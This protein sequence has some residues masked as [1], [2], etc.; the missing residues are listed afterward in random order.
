[1]NW[2]TMIKNKILLPHLVSKVLWL[3]P[4]ALGDAILASSMLQPLHDFYQ[5]ATITVLCQQQLKSLYQACPFVAMI[6]GFDK[7]KYLTDHTYQKYLLDQLQQE[8][9]DMVLNS[10]YSREL[11]MDALATKI[12]A[13]YTVAFKINKRRGRWDFSFRYNRHYWQLVQS[14][15][16]W[17][18]ELARYNDFLKTL[19]VNVQTLLP[20]I[21]MCEEDDVF[22]DSFFQQHHLNART[23]I[24]FFAGA[25][26]EH[27]L[28]Y[29]YGK[30]IEQAFG[31]SNVTV[32]TFGAAAD[33]AINQQNLE[34]L[35][36][37][38]IDLS[39]KTTL[40]QAAAI[41]KRCSLAFGAETGLA[42]MACAVG[43]PNVILLGGGHMGR[44][45][46]YSPL[47]SAVIL[48]LS[49]YGC[50]WR[51]KYKKTYCVQDVRPEVLA[52]VLRETLRTV[53][54]KPRIFV[55]GKNTFENG[56]FKPQWQWPTKF[57]DLSTV[58]VMIVE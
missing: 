18:P 44:F 21:W 9:F 5:H 23:T 45:M 19:G 22:A 29:Q 24:A 10:V 6:I 25:T 16:A 7:K 38:T 8:Q 13:Q 33:S 57:L 50:D 58:D 15:G 14:T 1:M 41:M 39:G 55:Q 12:G 47:T 4:D 32:I 3:R 49:C 31:G 17:K 46:P 11:S 37:P 20:R 51:C 26:S 2:H 36:L 30:A 34:Q 35:S 54:T 53:A 48:P 56:L 52:Y 28:Y 42:H 43:I 27:R 40:L